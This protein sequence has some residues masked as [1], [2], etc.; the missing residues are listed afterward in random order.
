MRG[1]K[2]LLAI[3]YVTYAVLLVIAICALFYVYMLV[4]S[5]VSKLE[6][7]AG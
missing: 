5:E 6:L 7:Y 4:F 3:L 2:T 1:V